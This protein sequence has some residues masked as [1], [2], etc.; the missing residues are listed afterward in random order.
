MYSTDSQT[1]TCSCT[2]WLRS[3]FYLCKHLTRD[4]PV[5]MYRELTIRR[6]P[7]FIKICKNTTRCRANIAG[8]EKIDFAVEPQN[9]SSADDAPAVYHDID[10]V[11]DHSL[12]D[13]FDDLSD[14]SL[15]L[16][17]HVDELRSHPSGK[18][19]LQ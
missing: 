12:E 7:P 5:P 3:P 8:E 10:Y 14:L 9:T 19:R 2:A 4:H 6:T 16:V 13:R 18:E 11:I 1:F 17:A 15:W